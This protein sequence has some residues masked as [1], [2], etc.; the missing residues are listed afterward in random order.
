M[1]AR[2]GSFGL[3]GFGRSAGGEEKVFFWEKKKWFGFFGVLGGV[4]LKVL[5]VASFLGLFRWFGFLEKKRVCD[6]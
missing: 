2:S 4:C 6:M 3:L 5:G 1:K